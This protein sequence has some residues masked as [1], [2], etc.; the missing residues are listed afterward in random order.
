MDPI[1]RVKLASILIFSGFWLEPIEL[2]TTGKNRI[3][4]YKAELIPGLC[5]VIL[6]GRREGKLSTERQKIIA[7]Q[8]DFAKISIVALVGEAQPDIETENMMP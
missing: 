5:E 6:K 8:C 2:T 3:V 7:D 4:G 1:F